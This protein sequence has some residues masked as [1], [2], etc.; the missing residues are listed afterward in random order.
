[1]SRW[2][3]A[4]PRGLARVAGATRG[5]YL[6]RDLAGWDGRP[7]SSPRVDGRCRALVVLS[8]CGLCLCPLPASARYFFSSR[9]AGRALPW[10]AG[11][12]SIAASVHTYRVLGGVLKARCTK[13]KQKTACSFLSQCSAERGP[14]LERRGPCTEA[15]SSC[16]LTFH[17]PKLTPC[18][19]RPW[20]PFGFASPWSPAWTLG[21]NG[22]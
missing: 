21:G 5:R 1:M 10:A 12:E 20:P 8:L 22:G 6:W 11:S 2:R 3:C 13:S 4:D 16:T 9:R 15:R 19:R 17:F 14:L 18:R 7:S